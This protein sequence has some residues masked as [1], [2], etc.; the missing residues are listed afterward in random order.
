MFIFWDMQSC[1]KCLNP[2]YERITF[3]QISFINHDHSEKK[4]SKDKVKYMSHVSNKINYILWY[5]KQ[6]YVVYK[7]EKKYVSRDR[8]GL[9]SRVHR[10]NSPTNARFWIEDLNFVEFFS[11]RFSTMDHAN[12]AI[13]ASLRFRTTATIT[14]QWV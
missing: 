13:V 11:P 1:F 10:N 3:V 6:Y 9:K 14:F 12:H 8:W 7:K 5:T 4:K 2:C